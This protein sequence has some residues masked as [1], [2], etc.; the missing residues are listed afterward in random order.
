[1]LFA[2]WL[3][4]LR[5]GQQVE[6]IT[7]ALEMSNSNISDGRATERQAPEVLC[8]PSRIQRG[9]SHECVINT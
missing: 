8:T 6:I 2:N 9:I 7:Q 5:S 1:M 4:P 3:R